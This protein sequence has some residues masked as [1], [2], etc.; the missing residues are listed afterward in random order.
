[1]TLARHSGSQCVGG[2]MADD[3]RPQPTSIRLPR[4]LLREV[5]E[6]AREDIRPR[7]SQVHVLLREA[8]DARAKAKAKAAAQ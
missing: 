6:S 3:E 4:S 1:M 7:Q 5:D 2:R 8:L